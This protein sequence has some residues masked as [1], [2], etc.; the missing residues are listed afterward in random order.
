M[1]IAAIDVDALV[2][3]IF[4]TWREQI[5]P[6]A[7]NLKNMNLQSAAYDV[8]M[9]LLPHLKKFLQD[10]PDNWDVVLADIHNK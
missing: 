7:H 9:H 6:L 10:K 3:S 1:L 5:W 4:L 8:S 2:D